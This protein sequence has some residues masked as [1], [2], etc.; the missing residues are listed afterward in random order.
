MIVVSE[1]EAYLQGGGPSTLVIV[2]SL[3]GGVV[4]LGIGVLV[5]VREPR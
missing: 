4:V 2:G 5:A 1:D 3:L